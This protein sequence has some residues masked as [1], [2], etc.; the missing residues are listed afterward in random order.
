[1]KLTTLAKWFNAIADAY[2]ERRAPWAFVEGRSAAVSTWT[3]AHVAGGETAA[4]QAV[5]DLAR[6]HGVR[7]GKAP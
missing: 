5:I 7:L 2:A 3:A 6:Q 1:M 4:E